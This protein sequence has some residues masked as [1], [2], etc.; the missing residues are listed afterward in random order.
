MIRIY[1]DPEKLGQAAAMLFLEL[2]GRAI[3]EHGRF[4]VVLSGGEDLSLQP[5]DAL[6]PDTV[7]SGEERFMVVGAM[8]GG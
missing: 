4:S 3:S 1:N 7:A 2:A 5:P 8:A 6:L